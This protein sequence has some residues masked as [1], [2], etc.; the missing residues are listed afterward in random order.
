MLDSIDACM[1][2]RRLP[3]QCATDTAWVPS[4]VSRAAGG[5]PIPFLFREDGTHKGN[6]FPPIDHLLVSVI[7]VLLCVVC[8][9][10]SI[11]RNTRDATENAQNKQNAPAN[12]NGARISLHTHV[13]VRVYTPESRSVKSKLQKK[14]NKSRSQTQKPRCTLARA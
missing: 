8:F 2:R 3:K 10:F 5:W 6:P 14:N 4:P 12:K 13:H 9:F 7:F 1:T 11:Q